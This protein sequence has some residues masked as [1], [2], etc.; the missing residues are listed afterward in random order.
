MFYQ[1][2]DFPPV[3]VLLAAFLLGLPPVTQ[4]RDSVP[5]TR[6]G[7]FHVV[8]VTA[9]SV[10]LSW[11]AATDNRRVR[12]YILYR[13]D[14]RI[15]STNKLQYIDSGLQNDRTYRYE[16][17]A[18]DGTNQSSLVS[19][20]ATTL[21]GST[22]PP[23]DTE[24]ETPDTRPTRGNNGKGRTKPVAEPPP[25]EPVQET[26]WNNWPLVFSDEFTGSGELSTGAGNNWR[27]E[28]MS[29]GL[30]RAGNSGMNSQGNTDVPVWES[31]AGKRWSAW[32]NDFNNA[33]AYRSEGKLVMGG[34]LTARTDPTRPIN[35]IDDGV[36]IRYGDNRLYSS[37]IDTWSR[38]WVG[39]GDKHVVDPASPGIAFKYGYF[40]T[41]VN[42]SQMTTPGFRL[43]MWLM[44]ASI[45]AQG[46][47]LVTDK[48]YDAD[49]NN[50]VEIDL[51][52]YEWT[53]TEQENR[54]IMALHGG[55]AG[56]ATTVF[57]AGNHNISL[58]EGWHK[59]GLLWQQ[60]KLQWYVDDVLA[61]TVT[62]AY[63]I[64]DV[65]SYLIVSREMNSGVKTPGIDQIYAG[66]VESEPPYIPRDPGLY[67]ENIW[68]YKDRITTDQGL[69]D[70]I[71]VWA[72]P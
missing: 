49:G 71:K 18:S 29:D 20:M 50:G 43:S 51:F 3:M 13:D 44:P 62:E 28:T 22:P 48:A 31:P 32:Y 58:H 38:K 45:D 40:E 55:A 23:N 53:G 25:A 36:E 1:I 35:Y 57:N 54:I 12:S 15:A 59:I 7:N 46:Q 63:L 69:I 9:Q 16:V 47:Q 70:Y 41:S 4:A 61:H 27:Y 24:P 67:A 17:Q 39:P 26:L 21:A 14:V 64:P 37:W 52:E 8:S 56:S 68:K 60:D 19:I 11:N 30:H 2:R 42:F 33:N 5:P 34:Y 72:A 65:Y 66:D 6:P 10:S